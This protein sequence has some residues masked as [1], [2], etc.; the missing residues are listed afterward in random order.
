MFRSI[1]PGLVVALS[2]G[3]AL[4]TA[5]L[6]AAHMDD[7][8]CHIADQGDSP[9]AKACSEGGFKKAKVVMKNLTKQAKATGTKFECDDCHKNDTKYELTDEGRE[10]FKK[11]LAA[12]QAK[13]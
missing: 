11:L 10:K 2:V 3:L 8:K 1:R 6:A 5:G 12:V 7:N 13:R 9:V 4:A